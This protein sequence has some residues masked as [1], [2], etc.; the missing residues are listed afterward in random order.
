MGD[1][2][3]ETL[4]RVARYYL[5]QGYNQKE[6]QK[7]VEIFL[8]QCDSSA[9]I[10]KWADTIGYAVKRAKK[11]NAIYIDWVGITS[12]E[13]KKIASLNGAQIRRLAF[14]LLCLAK[15]WQRINQ[16]SDFWVNCKDSEILAMANINT[17]LKRQAEMYYTLRELGFVKFSKKVDNT[18][19]QVCFVDKT[20][21]DFELRISD[22]RNLGYQYLK[23]TGGSY[24]ECKNCGITTKIS[25]R[26]RGRTPVYCQQC[27]NEIAI[28]QR[29]NKVMSRNTV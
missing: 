29:V 6:A 20:Q 16:N 14:T 26:N 25:K 23:Y 5:D 17:S 7:L 24:I 21:D 9:S 28:R 18:N 2:P 11:Y 10:V 27:A 12:S 15:Y 13:L 19:V 4:C 22:F 8:L 1:K 3:F